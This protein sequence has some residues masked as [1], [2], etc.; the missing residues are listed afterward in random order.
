MSNATHPSTALYSGEKTPPN[1]PSCEHFAGNEKLIT[2][3]L[4]LQEE[5]GPIF[6]VTCDLEDGAAAG[7]EQ[8]H[9]E[10]A[11]R[12]VASD[13]NKFGQ[14]GIRIHDP[15]HPHWQQDV[16]IILDGCGERLAYITIPKVTAATQL[17]DVVDYIKSACNSR[18]IDREIPLHVL[19]ETHGALRDIWDI[20]AMDWVQV[21]DFGQ[22]DFVSAHNGAIPASA[23]RSPGQFE[24]H[25][26]VRAKT[27]IV[28]AAIGNGIVPAH[29][30]C[31]N[32]KD[33]DVVFSDASR[34]RNEFGFSRMW[35]IYPAQIEPIVRAMRPDHSEVE[36]AAAILLAAQAKDWGPIQHK[37]ELHD[38]ASYRYYWIILQRASVTGVEI[39]T[40]AQQAFFDESS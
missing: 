30:V 14:V 17:S 8:S 13:T 39:P 27:E 15:D 20:A 24:H 19:I 22:M 2:K 37:G 5:H 32:L 3:A 21:I 1:I 7:Q 33:Q 40:D 9:A 34:A 10:M 18:G 12:M 29:S 16:D 28:A 6:D 11:A 31:Q 23:M 36:D 38:R 4:A 25:L 26:I 35:S